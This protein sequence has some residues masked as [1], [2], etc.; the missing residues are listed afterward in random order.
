MSGTK[1]KEGL[2]LEQNSVK[3]EINICKY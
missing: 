1:V 3:I 2:K